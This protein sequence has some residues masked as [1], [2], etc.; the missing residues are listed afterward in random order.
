MA[1]RLMVMLILYLAMEIGHSRLLLA[2]AYNNEPQVP[3][4]YIFGDS[5][6]DVGT[7]N[8]LKNSKSR[9]DM[10]FYGIDFPNS[11]PT[12]RFSNGLNTADRL[13]ILLGFQESPLPYLYLKN[14]TQIFQKEILKGVN[15]ASGGSGILKHTG[16]F[17]Y[18][19]VVSMHEQIKQF[20]SVYSKISEYLN[21]SSGAEKR[22]NKSMFLI[23]VGSNDIFEFFINATETGANFTEV[24]PQFMSNLMDTYHS[25]L[26]DLISHGARKIGIVS[27]PPIG[28]V[29]IVRGTFGGN[30]SDGINA[31]AQFFHSSLHAMVSKLR[32]D[33]SDLKYSVANA[34]DITNLTM[35]D[36]PAP[37]GLSDVKTA[38]CGNETLTLTIPPSPIGVQCSPQASVCENRDVFLFWDQ[39]HPTEYAS[40]IAA[41]AFFTA[42]PEFVSPFNFSTLAQF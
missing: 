30:C 11:E 20:K 39:Y 38:C 7:N 14:N 25:H 22:I 42:G 18:Q 37:I 9:A 35:I 15:F 6:F 29:P 36:D 12:G 26:Q 32:I 28:C 24:V 21:E 2:E 8:F 23:S 13:A 3:A 34:Y 17:P 4:V 27:V 10:K 31:I 33:C 41:L 16:E 5:T 19:E 40:S 1:K